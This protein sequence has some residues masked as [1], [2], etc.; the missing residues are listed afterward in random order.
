MNYGD[1]LAAVTAN[2]A[3]I[4]YLD[5]GQIAVGKPAGLVLCRGAS[6]VFSSKVQKMWIAVEKQD[7]DSRQGKLG[8]CYLQK[9]PMSEVYSR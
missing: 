3:D 7:T 2:V 1:I 9:K 6:L 5:T 8:G 4:F